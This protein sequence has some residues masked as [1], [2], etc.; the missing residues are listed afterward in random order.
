M[1]SSNLGASHL[2]LTIPLY[3]LPSDFKNRT[4]LCCDRYECGVF[5]AGSTLVVRVWSMYMQLIVE[6]LYV[7][8]SNLLD[9]GHL[10]SPIKASFLHIMGIIGDNFEYLLCTE[11]KDVFPIHGHSFTVNT[12][13]PISSVYCVILS[14]EMGSFTVPEDKTRRLFVVKYVAY[15]YIFYQSSFTII[16]VTVHIK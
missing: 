5:T 11:Y 16:N 12:F 1:T 7:D 6:D 8:T 15:I 9:W 13:Q 14:L 10:F 4:A 3:V 2:K